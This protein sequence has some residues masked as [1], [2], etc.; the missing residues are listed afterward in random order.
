MHVLGSYFSANFLSQNL[1]LNSLAKEKLLDDGHPPLAER[2]FDRDGRYA[3]C[4]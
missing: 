3:L 4:A 2:L 1:Q